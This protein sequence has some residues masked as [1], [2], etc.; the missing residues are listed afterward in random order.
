MP[1][2]SSAPTTCSRGSAT[3]ARGSRRERQPSRHQTDSTGR[4]ISRADGDA[5]LLRRAALSAGRSGRRRRRSP[6]PA[7]TTS[8]STCA[9]RR[10]VLRR[11]V[12][13]GDAA[14]HVDSFRIDGQ[15]RL[16]RR[17]ARPGRAGPG[18]LGFA[19]Q[20]SR[21]TQ[22]RLTAKYG[23]NR[24]RFWLR[25]GLALRHYP[26]NTSRPLFRNNPGSGERSTSRSTAQRS[27]LIRR[28]RQSQA[29]R[30]IPS[31]R[32][33]GIRGRLGSIRPNLRKAKSARTRPHA[34]RQ[35]RPLQPDR[36]RHVAAAQVIHAE[37]GEDRARRR[38]HEDSTVA[39]FDRLVGNPAS[40]G[41]S[42]VPPG[43]PT[44]SILTRT[45][46]SLFDGRFRRPNPAHFDSKTTN[47]GLLG[48]RL[49]FEG[50]RS[51]PQLR[52]SSTCGSPAT[53]RR[54]SRST[55]RRSRRSSRSA[56]TR[57]ASSCDRS[58]TSPPSA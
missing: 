53:R 51:L 42:P 37:P 41:T 10:I 28:P 18:R 26:L 7:R 20:R 12:S 5:V 24:S 54:R 19:P 40:P 44:T 8:Q 34:E 27:G 2:T 36:P 33:P 57:A 30:P 16:V 21:S 39:Y 55:T 56:S 11:T 35:G 14:A 46:T 4:P 13:T 9:A 17:R 50:R 22:E 15:R 48:G 43:P 32:H 38:D 3:S 29:H 1:K 45:S 49:G 52:A 6:Q 25:P 31:A 23:V 47:N 58:S